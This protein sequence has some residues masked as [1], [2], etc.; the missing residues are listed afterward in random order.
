MLSD[1]PWKLEGMLRLLAA[2][3]CCIFC[4]VMAQV[5][6]QHFAGK[7][8]FDEG[9]LLFLV[10]TSFTLHG[11]IL[12]GTALYL[13]AAGIT[14]SEA[15]GFSTPP[16]SRA[17]LWGVG[18]VVIFLPVGMVLQDISIQALTA[19]HIPTPPQTAVEEFNK[20]VSAAARAYLTVFAVILAPIAEEV[21][22]RGLLYP[23]LK[24]FGR[25]Q[26]ALWGSAVVF[27]AIHKSAAIFLPLLV[28][29]VLLA[30]LYEKT[31]NLLA[32]I[33]AHSLFNAINVALLFGGDP[34]VKSLNHFFH[35]Q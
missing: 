2:I 4:C 19:F 12:I 34:L 10:F 6:V 11:S 23:A 22:F 17:I 21:F 30:W 25:P 27:A 28:L 13:W 32:S 14:W 33:T 1:K 16:V 18:A 5:I 20:C 24:Q 26:F 29:G 3:F 31:N 8:A 7:N 35:L 9:T 15:F